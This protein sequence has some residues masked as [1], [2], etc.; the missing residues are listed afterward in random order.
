MLA[1]LR[2][3]A[4]LIRGSGLGYYYNS[5]QMGTRVK[6][7]DEGFKVH[8]EDEEDDDEEKE[9]NEDGPDAIQRGDLAWVGRGKTCQKD[10]IPTAT[11]RYRT[12]SVCSRNAQLVKD[13]RG[14]T[15]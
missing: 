9:D 13:G 1:P 4:Q 8:E 7:V 6:G 10:G 15:I 5:R 14:G 3:R 11:D 12:G 2:T